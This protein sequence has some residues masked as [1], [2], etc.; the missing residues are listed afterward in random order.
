MKPFA[1]PPPPKCDA[2]TSG[3]ARLVTQTNNAAHATKMRKTILALPL[4]IAPFVLI[5]LPNVDVEKVIS[6]HPAVHQMVFQV[7]VLARSCIS[8]MLI[9]FQKAVIARGFVTQVPKLFCYL[10]PRSLRAIL[11]AILRHQIAQSRRG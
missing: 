6:A 3:K 4:C 8:L 9:A 1:A 2:A 5:L 7:P 11:G 10:F